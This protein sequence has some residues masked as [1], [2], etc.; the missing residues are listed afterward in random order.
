MRSSDFLLQLKKALENEL[1][2]AQVQDNVE[3][4]KNYIKEEMKSGKSEQEVMNM[5]GDPWA[6]AKTIL[7]EEKMSG[8]QESVNS[9]EQSGT[10]TPKPKDSSVWTGHLVEEGRGYFGIDCYYYSYYFFDIGDSLDCVADCN[11]FDIDCDDFQHAPPKIKRPM[12]EPLV[13][14]RGV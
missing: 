7:L 12:G 13:F 4:Y 2:A 5:L 14:L 11:S 9:E 6:I 1:S 8:T 10:D 3:Y